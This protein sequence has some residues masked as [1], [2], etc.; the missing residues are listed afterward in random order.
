[1]ANAKTNSISSVYW[2]SPGNG[3]STIFQALV[4]SNVGGATLTTPEPSTLAIAG[5]GALG[6]V[7][8][9]L[10]RPARPR[11]AGFPACVERFFMEG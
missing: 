6:F 2:L 11:R 5:L 10:R 9:G 1:M 8:Y 7:G 4:T 3:S